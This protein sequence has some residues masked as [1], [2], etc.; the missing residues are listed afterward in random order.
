MS[1]TEKQLK[2]AAQD[3]AKLLAIVEKRRVEEQKWKK[4]DE[5]LFVPTNHQFEDMSGMTLLDYAVMLGDFAEVRKLISEGATSK[6]A[7]RYAFHGGHAEIAQFLIDKKLEY[8]T[9]EIVKWCDPAC[10]PILTSLFK[11][12]FQKDLQDFIASSEFESENLRPKFFHSR[13]TFL[14]YGALLPFNEFRDLIKSIPENKI[15]WKMGL[16]LEDT[17]PASLGMQYGTTPV[18]YALAAGNQD[19]L[20]FLIKMGLNVDK[21]PNEKVGL[22]PLQLAMRSGHTA[23]A[24]SFI[25]HGAKID[26]SNRWGYSIVDLAIFS[27]NSKAVELALNHAHEV[28][29]ISG[30]GRTPIHTLAL[31][32]CQDETIIRMVLSHPSI[33]TM[34]KTKDRFGGTPADLAVIRGNTVLLQQL[35]SLVQPKTNATKEINISQGGILDKLSYFLKLTNLGDPDSMPKGG[36]CNGF[37]FL[38][39]YYR[40]RGLKNEFFNILRLISQWDG[41][42]EFLKQHAPVVQ[43]SGDYKDVSDL[44]LQWTNDLIWFQQSNLDEALKKANP[45]QASRSEQ[46]SIV[47]KDDLPFAQNMRFLTKEDM[48]DIEQL[49]EYMSLL[50]EMPDL[51]V[52]ISRGEHATSL[53]VTAQAQFDYYDPNQPDVYELM[54]EPEQ[55][56]EHIKETKYKMLDKLTADQ[57]MHLQIRYYQGKSYQ[58]F[59]SRQKPWT[60]EEYQDYYINSPNK[61][62]PLHVALIKNDEESFK[63]LLNLEGIDLF[64]KNSSGENVLEMAV[65]FGAQ[66]F[67]KLISEMKPDLISNSPNILLKCYNENKS[68]LTYFLDNFRFQHSAGLLNKAVSDRDLV[69]VEKLLDMGFS[70]DEK[71]F[72]GSNFSFFSDTPLVNA[73]DMGQISVFE[74][75]MQH[76]ATLP[77]TDT[78]CRYLSRQPDMVKY[79]L[80]HDLDKIKKLEYDNGERHISFVEHMLTNV[81]DKEVQIKILQYL[82]DVKLLTKEIVDSLIHLIHQFVE[83]NNHSAI[84]LLGQVGADCNQL[85]EQGLTPLLAAV[86]NEWCFRAECG[87]ALIQNGA[88]VK[89]TNKNNALALHYAIL[90][91]PDKEELVKNL[92]DAGSPVN[93]FTVKGITPLYLAVK[94]NKPNLVEILLTAGADPNFAPPITGAKSA[95]EVAKEEFP[96]IYDLIM[97]YQSKKIEKPTKRKSLL[98]DQNPTQIG[99][100]EQATEETLQ[101]D[102][103]PK[104]KP[105]IN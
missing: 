74:K 39:L 16:D 41:D 54:D 79:L 14:H 3:R 65:A 9:F 94:R 59:P 89:A 67:V 72:Q 66:P 21:K 19:F 36:H 33:R 45:T 17:D 62:T 29:L 70:P 63:R 5:K 24:T 97:K 10:K 78:F 58:A 83:A 48:L 93:H 23:A 76:G 57:K 68:Q 13:Y 27:K 98:F 34:A 49:N 44:F 101:N 92:I 8:D 69:L 86:E 40:K 46:Y 12:N 51:D 20:N 105:Q 30:F 64:L 55:I 96:E 11:A 26:E 104:Q 18:G 99:K 15:D 85:N 22:T 88:N 25:Q 103:K 7:V 32:N 73:V 61:L 28:N 56:S 53:T 42:P 50:K 43:F 87:Q 82:I 100:K 47:K 102:N 1:F 75:L 80:S 90:N 38:Y 77:A 37:A 52:E 71:S 4:R 91:M 31:A 35:E 81:Y 6:K 2:E 84:A 60:K 95:I